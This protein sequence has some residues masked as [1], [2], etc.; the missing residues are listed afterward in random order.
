MSDVKEIQWM[1]EATRREEAFIN[2]TIHLLKIKSVYDKD[3]IA[4]DA[5]FGEGIKEALDTMLALGEKDGFTVKNVDGYA[6]HIEY[7][8]GEEVVGVLC[9]LDVVPEGEGWSSHPYKPEI[10]NG[11]LYARGAMDDKGPTMAAYYGLKIIKELGLDLKKRVRIILGCDEESEWRC[12]EH[13]FQQE[14]MPKIGFAPDADFPLIYAEKGIAECYYHVS[15]SCSSDAITLANFESGRRLNM[16]PDVAKATVTGM[17]KAQ[18]AEAFQQYIQQYELGGE[19]QQENDSVQLLIKGFSAHGAEPFKGKNAAV[20]LANFLAKYELDK[21]GMQFL[22]FLSNL[23]MDDVLGE[24]LGIAFEDT[25]SGKLTVNVGVVTYTAQTGGSIGI[26]LRCPVQTEAEG[27]WKQCKESGIP[28]NMTF[29]KRA[30]T[31]PHHVDVNHPL[32]QTLLSVYQRQTNDTQSKPIAIG[33]GTYARTLET[34]VAFGPLF[35]GEE[36]MAHQKDEYATIE[37]LVR[38]IAI[39]AEAIYELAK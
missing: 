32:I 10:R 34:G 11:K 17:K 3:S 2:D 12:M 9:H 31:P 38:A 5:P 4:T 14:Q 8:E 1:H 15:P 30:Y 23:F 27:V 7:G 39:Y 33:G 29:E 35:P 6:G 28:Y 24:K 25:I 22:S 20:Y 37:H 26:N 13:Y 18:I 16:V 21:G 19:I 36:E